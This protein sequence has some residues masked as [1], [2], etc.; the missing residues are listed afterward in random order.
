MV[1]TIETC[2]TGAKLAAENLM[3]PG[4]FGELGIYFSVADVSL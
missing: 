3:Y 1:A 4:S 2:D